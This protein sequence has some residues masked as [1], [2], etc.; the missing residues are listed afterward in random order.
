MLDSGYSE[1]K[2]R[3]NDNFCQENSF[4]IVSIQTKLTDIVSQA[5]AKVLI[6][7]YSKEP[8]S[9]LLSNADSGTF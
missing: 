1:E 6:F 2:T 9:T 5:V 7:V 4:C 8:E 3:N